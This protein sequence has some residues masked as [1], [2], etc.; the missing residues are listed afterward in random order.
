MDLG[1]T[2]KETETITVIMIKVIIIEGMEEMGVIMVMGYI[3]HIPRGPRLDPSHP[4][5]FTGVDKVQKQLQIKGLTII[6]PGTGV[7]KF[8]MDQVRVRNPVSVGGTMWLYSQSSV[9]DRDLD[10]ELDSRIK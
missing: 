4:P 5:N 3:P 2:E 7:D 8:I 1:E 9:M 10:L 6:T